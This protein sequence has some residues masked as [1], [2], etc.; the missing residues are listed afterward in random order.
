MVPAHHS[1]FWRCDDNHPRVPARQRAERA[2]FRTRIRWPEQSVMQ[3][4][5][6]AQKFRVGEHTVNH[7]ILAGHI[8]V[9]LPHT[10]C[11]HDRARFVPANAARK[12]F[13]PARD[14]IKKPLAVL[15]HQRNG[16]LPAVRA[17]GQ[18]EIVHRVGEQLLFFRE[19][20]Y[21]DFYTPPWPAL[22]PA[23]SDRDPMARKSNAS[24]S[25]HWSLRQLTKALTAF[26]GEENVCSSAAKTQ[27]RQCH[28]Q[29]QCCE[30][31][32]IANLGSFSAPLNYFLNS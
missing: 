15:L 10:R 14:S 4:R 7:A 12:N 25:C 2:Q 18:R 21:Q 30:P 16:K 1:T 17:D 5:R 27:E 31:R 3:A 22:H 8:L 19:A 11:R 9:A 20:L 13:L 6:A 29:C 24:H 32:P 28:D 23:R 26:S